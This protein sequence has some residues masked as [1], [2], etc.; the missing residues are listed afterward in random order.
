MLRNARA[1]RRCGALQHALAVVDSLV[2]GSDAD[3]E[4]RGLLAA[5]NKEMFSRADHRG[6]AAAGD[7]LR[8]AQELYQEVFEESHGVQYW[9]GIN[10]ATLAFLLGR[11]S[12][13]RDLAQRVCAACDV[14]EVGSAVD[15]WRL[16]TRAEAALVLGRFG[17]AVA[18]YRRAVEVG[19]ERIGDIASTRQNAILLLDACGANDSDRRAIEDALKSPTVV[20]FAGLPI[21][22]A[23]APQGRFPPAIEGAVR[24]AIVERLE[25]LK[26][27][28]GYSGAAPGAEILFA[29]AM[30]ERQPSVVNVV[31][32]WPREKFIESHVRA[33]GPEWQQRFSSL[34]GDE[35]SAPKVH[36]VV[37]ASLGVGVDGPLYEGF[38]QQLLTGLARLHAYALGSEITAVVVTDSV[39]T[40]AS[41]GDIGALVE[42]WASVGIPLGPEN[43]ID[44]N[45][46]VGRRHSAAGN[47]RP[48]R[49]ESVSGQT[50]RVMA[51][52]FA[53]VEDYSRIAE[54]RLPAF[55]EYF[56]GGI[57]SRLGLKQYKP[58]NLRRVGDGLL[59][60]FSSVREAGLC[61]LE[62]VEWASGHSRPGADGETFW[63]RLGLPREMRIRV[64]LHAGP[65]FECIDPLTHAATFEGSHINY[66]ARIEPVTPGNQ[67]YASEAFAALTASW[68][69][70]CDDFTCEYVGRTSLAKK[71]GE[72]PLYH[73]Q[74]RS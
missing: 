44:L 73:V 40:A 37:N 60:V 50:S 64:A 52:L 71:A 67:V 57:G 31:L 62:L 18:G 68:P 6:D 39:P 11:N 21:D 1:L 72:Y 56:V 5:I 9:H 8:R 14:V 25:R 27:G 24:A 30:L 49:S 13:A 3:G 17:D 61:A 19:S 42:R 26:A 38:A 32:P 15:Y 55:V 59:M 10:A 29:E 46:A 12:D 43:I 4:R 33:A 41:G 20:V 36:H 48:A 53:D 23:G 51:I 69:A 65:V 35:A 16:A 54:D 47:R 74:R 2:D 34:L 63:S 70:P 7:F 22:R 28:L 45:S 58:D 66:A